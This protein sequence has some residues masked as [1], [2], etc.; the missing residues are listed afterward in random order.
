MIFAERYVDALDP[1]S[2]FQ[3]ERREMETYYKRPRPCLCSL[4]LIL[5]INLV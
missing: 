1:E 2:A 4:P 5:A 3:Y